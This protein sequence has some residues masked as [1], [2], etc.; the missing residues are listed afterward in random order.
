M[1]YVVAGASGFL[2]TALTR[3]LARDGHDVVRLVRREPTA[4][5]E[6]QWDPYAGVL[7]PDVLTGAD[8]VV[9]LAGANIGRPWTPRYKSVLRESRVRTTATLADAVV[10]ADGTP[11]LLVQSGKSA[12][13]EDRGDEVLTE[14]AER[15]E[16]FLADVCR[17]WEGAT[18]PAAEA[19]SRVAYLRTGVV[20]ASDALAFRV[21][22]LPF[23][24]GVGGR[25]GSGRQF[26][27]TISV[28]DWLRAV[29]FVAEHNE[30]SGPVNLTLPEP[31][32][33]DEFVHALASGLHRPA[34]FPVPGFVLRAAAGDLAW[35]MIGSTRAVPTRLLDAGFT[36]THPDIGSA[37]AAALSPARSS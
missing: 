17:L 8:V 34:L 3:D 30:L 5:D 31:P 13:G 21:M 33:Y 2:G 20:L 4:A 19:G 24:F 35:E 25:L 11:A 29:R 36:F 32:R 7:D 37:V 15:G 27:A 14:D 6:R 22:A 23:R 9:N 18:A 10:K 16:G 26:F 1:R 12:Y 28:T